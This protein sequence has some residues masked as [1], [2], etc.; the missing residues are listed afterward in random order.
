MTLCP[1]YAQEATQN[2]ADLTRTYTTAFEFD[3]RKLPFLASIFEA[4]GVS[5]ISSLSD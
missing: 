1:A 5:N 3:A 2:F 4:L